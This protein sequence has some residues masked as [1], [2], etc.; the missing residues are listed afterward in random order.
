LNDLVDSDILDLEEFLLKPYAA[1]LEAYEFVKKDV[2]VQLMDLWKLLRLD[3][4]ERD[5]LN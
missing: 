4:V 1:R 3:E 2:E 5:K